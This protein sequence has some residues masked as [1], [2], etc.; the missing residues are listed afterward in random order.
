MTSRGRDTTAAFGKLAMQYDRRKAK[1]AQ[2]NLSARWEGVL[3]RREATIT[4][5][6][7]NG[8]F[9]LT[10]GE[11][12]SK[13]LVRLEIDLGNEDPVF[14]WAEVVDQSYDIGF[15]LRFTSAEDTDVGRLAAF[16]EELLQKDPAAQE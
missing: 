2:V 14:L 12:S 9:V 3:E 6:S 15:A 16:V 7:A 1:R 5:L 8:C 10:G 11:V 13:E 4:S